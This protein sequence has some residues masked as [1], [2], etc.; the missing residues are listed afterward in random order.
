LATVRTALICHHDNRSSLAVLPAWLE[1]FSDLV[2]IVEIVEPRR[3]KFTRLRAEARRSGW[4]LADVLAFRVYHRL[5]FARADARRT[6]LL[7]GDLMVRYGLPA[8]GVPVLQTTDANSESTREFLERAAPDVVFA[9]CKQ[10]LRPEVFETASRGTV[11]AHPGICPE[12][13][14]AHGCFWALARRDLDRVGA[15]LLRI[16]EGVDT[17]PVLGYYH[18]PFDESRES[19]VVIQHRVVF[20][21]L[22]RIAADLTAFAAGDLVAVDTSGRDSRAWGQ[23]RL[24]DWLRWKRAARRRTRTAPMTRVGRT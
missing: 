22:D 19:H 11:V 12:Y 8:E 6:D 7:D 15:T 20:E 17:G 24:S 5:R 14:N 4:R 10:L 9:R 3:R 16:D 18:A 21:N 13:R 1:S 2:A 23:P